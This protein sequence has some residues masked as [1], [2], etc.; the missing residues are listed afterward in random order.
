[1]R[2]SV[3]ARMHAR[4]R[5]PVGSRARRGRLTGAR[6]GGMLEGGRRFLA[7]LAPLARPTAGERL[8]GSGG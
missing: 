1:M 8:A 5:A 7:G 2:S 6:A 3:H 4:M